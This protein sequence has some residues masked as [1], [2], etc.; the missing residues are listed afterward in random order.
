MQLGSV[1]SSVQLISLLGAKGTREGRDM[2]MQIK[3]PVIREGVG[4]EL[5]LGQGQALHSWGRAGCGTALQAVCWGAGRGWMPLLH[6]PPGE[7]CAP[8]ICAHYC[9]FLHLHWSGH[10]GDASTS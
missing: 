2:G 1:E 10:E 4:L 3:A 7:A 5:G 8:Q 6:A 9:K